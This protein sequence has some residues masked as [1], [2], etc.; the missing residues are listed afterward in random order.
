MFTTV[1]K[2]IKLKKSD[3]EMVA[4]YAKK[5]GIPKAS[6]KRRLSL[7]ITLSGRQKEADIDSMNK[8]A[9]D[10]CVACGLLLGD[11]AKEAE[12]GG[13]EYQRGLE[14]GTLLILEDI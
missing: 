2:R 9:L 11:R 4:A 6:G 14:G 5:D 10:A 13:V 7:I 12:W 3:H 1:K 8:V